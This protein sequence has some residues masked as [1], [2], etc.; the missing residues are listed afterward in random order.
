[1]HGLTCHIQPNTKLV[2]HA[3]FQ[4]GVLFVP[5]AVLR[6]I[7]DCSIQEMNH[8]MSNLPIVNT[9]TVCDPLSSP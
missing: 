3:E 7:S 2:S 4:N 8:L 5:P 1:M 9:G 6:L